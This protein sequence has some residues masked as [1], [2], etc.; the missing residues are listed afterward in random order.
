M[1]K[2]KRFIVAFVTKDSSTV[3]DVQERRNV[4]L[5]FVTNDDAVVICQILNRNWER[6]Q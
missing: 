2:D 3:Y 6:F 5:Y 4:L 1:S